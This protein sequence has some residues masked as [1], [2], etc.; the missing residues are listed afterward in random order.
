MTD[1]LELLELLEAEDCAV[2]VL[3]GQLIFSR[4]PPWARLVHPTSWQLLAAVLFGAEGRRY[5]YTD[6]VGKARSKTLRHVWARCDVCG[7]GTMRAKSAGLKK[8]VITPNCE[9]KH[10]P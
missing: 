2:S 5:G 6:S 10:Q 7:E 8:C 1:P 4:P 3:D 9:G